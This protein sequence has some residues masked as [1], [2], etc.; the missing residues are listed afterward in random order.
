MKEIYNLITKLQ[1]INE[2]DGEELNEEFIK[3]V[4]DILELDILVSELVETVKLKASVVLKGG[5]KEVDAGLVRFIRSERTTKFIKGDVQED[6][7]EY[8]LNTKKVNEFIK[9]NN[10]LPDGVGEKT[11]VSYGVKLC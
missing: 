1:L 4:A 2:F 11:T 6:L 3:M 7:L 5:Q 8:K 9:N 10:R